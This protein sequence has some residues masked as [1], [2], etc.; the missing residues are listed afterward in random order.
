MDDEDA[1]RLWLRKLVRR[2]GGIQCELRKKISD[3]GPEIGDVVAEQL[4]REKRRAVRTTWLRG[5][6]GG[7]V[8]ELGGED[9]DERET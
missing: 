6:D 1:V 9:C 2:L 7:G 3:R 8:A 4:R 5:G